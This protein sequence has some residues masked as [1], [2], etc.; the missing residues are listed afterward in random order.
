MP[1]SSVEAVK[2]RARE[3]GFVGCG[4]THPGPTAHGERLDEWLA[5]GYAGTMRYLHRQ[6]ARRKEPR[7]NLPQARAVVVVLDN[8]YHWGP[9]RRLSRPPHRQVCPRAGLP[10][11]HR[12]SGW[13][14]SADVLRD[15]RRPAVAHAYADDG[16]VPERE[17][18]QRAGP[19]VDRQEHH[20]HSARRRVVLLH[21]A[22]L[23]RSRAS[24]GSSLRARSLR[25]LHPV[26][27]RLSRHT[28]SSSRGC[29][30]RL[31]A[32]PISRS[33]RS[34]PIPDELAE[35]FRAM[36]SAVTSA[37]TSAPGISDSPSRPAH[38]SFSPPPNW[39][40]PDPTSSSG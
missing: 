7:V 1:V 15:Q 9:R 27:R 37:T 24:A 32:S 18:A 4:I 35:R 39:A 33:S 5:K 11:R 40:E 22:D 6:A 38:P 23:H 30:T 13:T 2:A 17:L 26:P 14:C 20:A 34:G 28:R 3:L 25:Q 10:P 16:P 29:S 8:Y 12:T 19:R 31:D 21:R 36:P